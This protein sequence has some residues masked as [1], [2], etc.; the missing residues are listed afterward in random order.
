MNYELKVILPKPI[1]MNHHHWNNPH[2]T[3]GK[4]LETKEPLHIST[5][6]R[7]EKI[8]SIRN[9]KTQI[10]K[11]LEHDRFLMLCFERVGGRD[12]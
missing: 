7:F 1:H 12:D 3:R 9:L 5:G 6:F 10:W 2:A 4:V 8:N 11:E